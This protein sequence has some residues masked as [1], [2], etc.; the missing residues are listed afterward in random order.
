MVRLAVWGINL[1]LLLLHLPV[2]YSARLYG[3]YLYLLLIVLYSAG[4]HWEFIYYYICTTCT[5]I[6]CSLFAALPF[7]YMCALYLK[8]TFLFIFSHFDLNSVWINKSQFA[9]DTFVLIIQT[10]QPQVRYLAIQCLLAH[11][12]SKTST[13][14][15]LKNGIL[16]VL[17]SCVGVA[18]DGSIGQ[19][20]LLSLL[21]IYYY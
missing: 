14:Y 18:T 20:S 16:N 12:D 4:L 3:E 7:I 2:L 10:M 17:S 11:L 6:F 19:C 1:L 15:Q 9:T 13:E 21:L 8:Y 5:C